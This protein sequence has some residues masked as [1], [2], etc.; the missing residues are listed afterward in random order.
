MLGLEVVGEG[1]DRKEGEPFDLDRLTPQSRALAEKLLARRP[2]FR[3]Y[4]RMEDGG[5]GGDHLVLEV[6]SPT[7]DS[8]RT[9]CLWMEG[10]NEPSVGF[11]PGW[12]THDGLWPP[13]SEDPDDAAIEV[14]E[15]ALADQLAVVTHIGGEYDGYQDV[16]DLRDPDALA[17]E[18][19]RPPGAPDRLR[20]ETWSGQHDREV[21]PDDIPT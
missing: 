5:E 20:V 8:R 11:G 17:D 2:D 12:H 14:V 7:G 13:R 3:S 9:V 4:M 1:A 21:G 16:V 19:T 18:L 15:V 6:P 10:G